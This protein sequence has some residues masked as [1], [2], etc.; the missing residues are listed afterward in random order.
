MVIHPPPI[1]MDPYEWAS[2]RNK[3]MRL[4]RSGPSVAYTRTVDVSSHGIAALL[5]VSY[6]CPSAWGLTSGGF[7]CTRVVRSIHLFYFYHHVV[8]VGAF[9][10]FG[11]LYL[12]RTSSHLVSLLVTDYIFLT[13]FHYITFV[14]LIEN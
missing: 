7:S 10:F 9:F 8:G 5:S 2:L 13:A 1:K 11:T 12:L 6:A 3:R 4:V 14:G